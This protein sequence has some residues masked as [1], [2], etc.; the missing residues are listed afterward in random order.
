MII[1]NKEHREIY[2][3]EVTREIPNSAAQIRVLFQDCENRRW[4]NYI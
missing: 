4:E 1:L 3:R 2:S